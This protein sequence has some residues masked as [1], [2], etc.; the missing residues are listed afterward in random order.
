MP[1][2]TSPSRREPARIFSPSNAPGSFV[3]LGIL[4]LTAGLLAGCSPITFVVGV[5]PGDQR[6]ERTTVV[7]ETGWGG[8][9]VAL[10][11]VSGMIVNAHKPALLQQGEN[12]VS[13]FHEQLTQA[14]ADPRVKAVVLR[15]NTPGGG[16]TASD[17]MYRD[18]RRFRESTGKPVVALLMDVAASGGYY[19]ACGADRIVAYP[20]SV[21]GS[22]GVILQ[23]ISVKPALD[24][25]GVQ[26]PALTSGENK[27]AGSP[28]STLTDSH[29][30]VLQQLVDDY[31]ARFVALVRERRP[32]IDADQMDT[33]TD[34]RVFSG[35]EAAA[36]GLV[37]AT[38]DLHDAVALAKTLAGI[39]RADWVRYHRPLNHVGSPYA[40]APV[41]PATGPPST[42]LNVLQFNFEG[43]AGFDSPVGIYYLWRPTLP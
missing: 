30:A 8:D 20:T 12:P 16:V 15:L 29:R 38:G 42:Q 41:P 11:D 18:L 28:F 27:N 24:R 32:D 2:H 3:L 21:T 34:G 14:A 6:L 33:V 37:D 7:Q 23:T 10:I 17:M 39:D 36:M 13:L 9:R 40:A 4:A 1:H 35:E 22:V 43:L 25:I 19:L 31:Y 26:T 5:S